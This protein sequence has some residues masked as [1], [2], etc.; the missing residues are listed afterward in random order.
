MKK[1]DLGIEKPT[2]GESMGTSLVLLIGLSLLSLVVWGLVWLFFLA[3]LAV[4]IILGV[5][6][7]WAVLSI[8]IRYTPWGRA[9]FYGESDKERLEKKVAADQR[10]ADKYNYNPYG[11]RK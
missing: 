7:L 4:G 9:I 11:V 2:P 3:P 10:E 1:N 8:V 5:F 6:T